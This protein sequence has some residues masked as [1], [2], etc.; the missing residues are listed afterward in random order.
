MDEDGSEH[1][2]YLLDH[3]FRSA[4][5]ICLKSKSSAQL[6]IRVCSLGKSLRKRVYAL[7]RDD[8][9]E[10]SKIIKLA[11]VP[12]FTNAAYVKT[13]VKTRIFTILIEVHHCTI[14][15]IS[16]HI[17]FYIRAVVIIQGHIINYIKSI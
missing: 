12:S 3:H 6:K 16:V 5:S 4:H 7:F 14:I 17:F 11:F 1:T 13:W 15:W 10:Q 9:L 8:D 2:L